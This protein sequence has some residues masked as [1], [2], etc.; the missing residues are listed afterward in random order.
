MADPPTYEETKYS[1]DDESFTDIISEIKNIIASDYAESKKKEQQRLAE[2]DSW[3]A[4]EINKLTN[5]RNK[6]LQY[7]RTE[8]DGEIFRKGQNYRVAL[9]RARVGWINWF[10]GIST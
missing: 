5:E 8:I 10:K 2:I 7:L 1:I 6:R 4:D 3:Y 9:G